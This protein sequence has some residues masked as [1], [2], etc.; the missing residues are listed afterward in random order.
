MCREVSLAFRF[1]LKLLPDKIKGWEILAKIKGSI[2]M[3]K[4]VQPKSCRFVPP[5]GASVSL[6]EEVLQRQRIQL[7]VN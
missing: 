4:V 1:I 2:R 6:K 5:E 7:K 3:I